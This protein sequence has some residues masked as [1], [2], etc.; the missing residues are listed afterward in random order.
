M[1]IYNLINWSNDAPPPINASNLNYMDEGIRN[2]HV[3]IAS[4]AVEIASVAAY[5]STLY[6]NISANGSAISANTSSIFGVEATQSALSSQLYFLDTNVSAQTAAIASNTQAVASLLPVVDYQSSQ[7]SELYATQGAHSTSIFEI[8]A[9]QTAY[10][11]QLIGLTATQVQLVSQVGGQA[12]VLSGHSTQ[13]YE[14]QEQ[15]TAVS[16]S[17]VYMNRTGN[18]PVDLWTESDP[19]QVTATG[20][21]ARAIG[22]KY[23][24]AAPLTLAS[25][26]AE[27]TVEALANAGV[28]SASLQFSGCVLGPTGLVEAWFAPTSVPVIATS[29][30]VSAVSVPLET[31][32]YIMQAGQP[33]YLVLA[34]DDAYRFSV[35]GQG[36]VGEAASI[37]RW[38]R[39]LAYEWDLPL[40]LNL[41]SYVEFPLSTASSLM[42]NVYPALFIETE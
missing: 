27:F 8:T 17:L 30:V 19:V 7:I 39:G 10:D 31:S 42:P 11:L 2:A 40:G 16:G 32:D 1:T 15:A 13:I 3:E 18:G 24:P 5:A 21:Y 20:G 23:V 22:L 34:S 14:L 26:V 38:N 33:H 37:V 35:L 12:S 9:T 41:A 29:T 6:Q 25:G 4:Q 36:A 28:A